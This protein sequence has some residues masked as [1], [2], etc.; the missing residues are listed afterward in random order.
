MGAY[1]RRRLLRVRPRR[2]PPPAATSAVNAARSPERLDSAQRQRHITATVP[3][4]DY[5]INASSAAAARTSTD[6]STTAEPRGI[7]RHSVTA[8][9]SPSH[10]AHEH[11]RLSHDRLALHRRFERAARSL[12]YLG[13]G[14]TLGVLDLVA[15]PAVLLGDGGDPASAARTRAHKHATVCSGRAFQRCRRPFPAARR[16]GARSRFSR[17]SCR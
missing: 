5:Q 9:T 17:P 16:N 3:T 7:S 12:A 14:L 2:P 1:Q 8:A 13:L 15:V 4:G 10:R 6:S 11:A